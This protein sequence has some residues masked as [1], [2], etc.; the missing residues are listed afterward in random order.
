MAFLIGVWHREVRAR[1]LTASACCMG[2]APAA[3]QPVQCTCKAWAMQGPAP[4]RAPSLQLPASLYDGSDLGLQHG[5]RSGRKLGE[6]EETDL[7]GALEHVAGTW[8]Q[9]PEGCTCRVAVLAPDAVPA[10]VVG[11]ATRQ[12]TTEPACVRA[13]PATVSVAS[14]CT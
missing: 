8:A 11:Q 4:V 1:L 12:A 7:Q 6:A 10:W 5:F 2:A 13:E 9:R 14:H 3:A